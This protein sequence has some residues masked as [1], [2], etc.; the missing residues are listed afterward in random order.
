MFGNI[1]INK[2][3]ALAVAITFI[4]MFILLAMLITYN[5]S[6]L[7]DNSF[8]SFM[9]M[10]HVEFMVGTAL[11]GVAVGAIVFYLM[12]E[13]VEIKQ[14]ESKDNAKI[15]LS[16]LGAEERKTIEYLVKSKGSAY[17]SEISRLEGMS[18]LKAYRAI[19]KLESKNV[20]TIDKVGKA[21]KIT[22]SPAVFDA[23]TG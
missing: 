22:L 2:R 21:R 4:F 23:L 8:F 6:F 17:Q 12:Q 13:R 3:V 1:N 18:R 15:L 20:I 19:K 9:G 10:Y 11:L 5:P 14:K 16:F 7:G